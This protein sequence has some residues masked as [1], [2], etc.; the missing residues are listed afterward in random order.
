MAVT[1]TLTEAIMTAAAL[2][3]LR[4]RLH[5]LTDT[6]DDRAVIGRG[7]RQAPGCSMTPDMTAGGVTAVDRLKWV[8]GLRSG[9]RDGR[10]HG[11]QSHGTNG[12]GSYFSGGW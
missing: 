5:E 11:E 4:D 1:L 8:V 12:Q 6:D 7:T 2:P 10:E 3:A 9:G